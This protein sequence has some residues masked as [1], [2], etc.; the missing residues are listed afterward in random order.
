MSKTNETFAR[1]SFPKMGRTSMFALEGERFMR[2]YTFTLRSATLTPYLQS[3]QQFATFSLV[4][5]TVCTGG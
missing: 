3:N 1:S 5:P 4:S 2:V